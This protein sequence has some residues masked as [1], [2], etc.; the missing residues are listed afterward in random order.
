MKRKSSQKS[1]YK[2]EPSRRCPKCK[3]SMDIIHGM[4]ICPK[5][6]VCFRVKAIINGR[7]V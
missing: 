3:T 1:K 2:L 5:D 4:W 7:L 6:G